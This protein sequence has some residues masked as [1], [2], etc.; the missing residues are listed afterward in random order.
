MAVAAKPLKIDVEPR[1]WDNVFAPSSCLV[2]I[3]TV[4]PQGRVNAAAFGTCTRVCHEPMYIAF[5]CSADRDT[6]NNALATGE[7][8]VNVVPFEQAVLDKVPVC[9]LPF[10]PGVHVNYQET[11]LPIHDGVTKLRDLPKEMGGSGAS[12]P[13]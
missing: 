9:G 12:L 10:K 4:D 13:E 2:L 8:V 6:T 1:W 5:T 11:V 7:F 3:T